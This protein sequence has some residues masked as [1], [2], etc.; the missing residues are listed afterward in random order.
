LDKGRGL[1][2]HHGPPEARADQALTIVPVLRD[3]RIGRDIRKFTLTPWC[4]YVLI[5]FMFAA[6]TTPAPTWNHVPRDTKP[7]DGAPGQWP[8]VERRQPVAD[9]A[10]LRL[11]TDDPPGFEPMMAALTTPS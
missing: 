7:R 9:T 11:W 4:W 2:W 6:P 5:M 1:P 3:P 10:T 8:L